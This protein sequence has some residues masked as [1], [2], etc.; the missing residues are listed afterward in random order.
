MNNLEVLDLE[1]LDYDELARLRDAVNLQMLKRRRTTGLRLNELLE[2]LEEVKTTLRDQGKDWRS[3][4]RWQYIDGEICF[5][6]NPADQSLYNMGWFSIDALLQWTHD[7]GPVM[8][9][10]EL[11]EDEEREAPGYSWPER[12]PFDLAA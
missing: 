3:L 11:D 1:E 12:R 8:V 4:E 9:Q 2:L 6:L 5:W 7:T 10:E